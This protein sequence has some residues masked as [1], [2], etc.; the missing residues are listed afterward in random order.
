MSA[1]ARFGQIFFGGETH[2]TGD[3]EL[4]ERADAHQLVDALDA[5]GRRGAPRRFTV[6]ADVDD[7]LQDIRH[8]AGDVEWCWPLPL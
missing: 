7:D 6:I 1:S 5:A 8:L 4:A 2:Q 3:H